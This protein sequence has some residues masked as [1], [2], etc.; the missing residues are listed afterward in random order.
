MRKLIEIKKKSL[1]ICDNED[2]DYDIPY[3]K[4]GEQ[5]IHQYI[6]EPCPQCGENLL[7]LEDYRLYMK[8][9]RIVNF[10]N[11][12]FSWITIF[13]KV[14]DSKKTTIHIHNGINFIEDEEL[15]RLN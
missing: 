14:D 2:C 7:T 13:Y 8:L 9:T 1:I 15:R 11:K 5:I 10:L 12:W 4:E 6:N 3:S